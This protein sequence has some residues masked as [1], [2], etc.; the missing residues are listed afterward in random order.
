MADKDDIRSQLDIVDIIGETVS[1]TYSGGDEWKGAINSGSQ[2]GQSLSVNCCTQVWHDWANDTGGDVFAWIAQVNNLDQKQDFKQ[3]LAIAAERAGVELSCGTNTELY[4]V[5]LASAN[6]YHSKLTVDHRKHIAAKWGLSNETIDKYLIG[7]APAGTD[8]MTLQWELKEVFSH[9]LIKSTGLITKNGQD[10]YQDR[11]VFPYFKDGRVVY[12]IARRLD[13][14][15]RK[16]L[17]QQVN[18]QYQEYVDP[19]IKNII[20][21]QDSLKDADHCIITEGVTDC[22]AVLQA[23]IP[24][25]SPVTVQFN[26]KDHKPILK[27]VKDLKTVYICNDS[28]VSGAGEKGAQSTAELLHAAGINVAV[29]Q[30]PRME[31]VDKVDLADYLRDN[32]VD[33]FRELMGAAEVKPGAVVQ[34]ETGDISNYLTEKGKFIPGKMGADMVERAA[35]MTFAD[36]FELAPYNNGVFKV[37]RGSAY[38]QSKIQGCLGTAFTSTARKKEVVDF[39]KH[40]T[41][42]ERDIINPEMYMLN[43]RNGMY[44]VKNNK[45]L[46]HDLKYKS[47]IQLNVMYDPDAECP[48]INRFL[49][50][51]MAL[52]DVLVLAQYIGYGM[53]GAIS[54]QRSVLIH[55][56]RHNGKSTFLDIITTLVGSDHITR[57]SLQQLSKDKYAVGQLNGKLFNIHPDLSQEKIYDTSQFKNTTTDLYL[58]GEEKYIPAFVFKNT[59]HHIFSANDIPD[60]ANKEE[61]AFFRRWIMVEFPN[62]FEGNTDVKNIIA[63]LSTAKEISGYFN[64]CMA[65]LRALIEH[66][67]FCK[68]E[69]AKEIKHR[70]LSQSNPVYAYMDKCTRESKWDIVK[71]DLY[72]D[73]ILWCGESNRKQ[74]KQHVFGKE[75]SNLGYES[76]REG[77]GQRRTTYCNLAL[78]SRQGN[79][80]DAMTDKIGLPAIETWGSRQGN[81]SKFT[82]CYLYNQMYRIDSNSENNKE[83]MPVCYGSPDVNVKSPPGGTV[84]TLNNQHVALTDMPV[85]LTDLDSKPDS[86]THSK[87]LGAVGED[88]SN[89]DQPEHLNKLVL[90]VERY[91]RFNKCV[92][93]K[94]NYKSCAAEFIKLNPDQDYDLVLT[95]LRHGWNI[96]DNGK[97]MT[98]VKALIDIPP[99]AGSN[100]VKYQLSVG[101]V[102]TIPTVN[103]TGLIKR[104]AAEEVPA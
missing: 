101:A 23:G 33:A 24:C 34:S 44:D 22:L 11:I 96:S 42:C 55:G 46:P 17:K 71:S 6:W 81:H 58:N 94:N 72:E 63:S 49:G 25:V 26:I 82:Y 59:C 74:L 104:Q 91:E 102:E 27:L 41:L 76:G 8:G 38:T 21:G 92:L 78:I 83:F 29:I 5:L 57:K 35:Y 47:T 51:V 90:A 19:A 84:D 88:T 31:G 16:Y 79:K 87:P 1:L 54:Q 43:L 80:E 97:D 53:T 89:S 52:D 98:T 14:G 2:S 56:T 85:A 61:E 13:E 69:S 18:K 68:I 103:A 95:D 75:L 3:V 28:E 4:T 45:L 15:D 66:G 30:L 37:D 7:Y 12:S 73:Y 36:T 39:I 99:F 50:Q 62:T 77:E 70:Y 20:F 67:E 65:G 60:V 86:H 48:N 64:M 10:V 40:A 9:D 100:G 93:G 32:P